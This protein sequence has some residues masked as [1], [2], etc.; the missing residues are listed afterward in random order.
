MKNIGSIKQQSIENLEQVTM[1]HA[2][3]VGGGERYKKGKKVIFGSKTGLHNVSLGRV[4]VS[5]KYVRDALL[6]QI[7]LSFAVMLLSTGKG[8]DRGK[9]R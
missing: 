3:K 4:F 2:V 8:Q 9:D 7:I 5:C 1:L 6:M